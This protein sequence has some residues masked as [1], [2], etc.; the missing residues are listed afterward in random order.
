MA[1]SNTWARPPGPPSGPPNGGKR[2]RRVLI[3]DDH[4]IVR[5]GLRRV[6]ENEDDLVVCGE[7]ESARDARTAIKELH[8]DVVIADISLKQGDGIE[9]VRDVRAHHPTLPILVLSMHDE[10]IYAERMLSAGA[11]GYIMKQAA[12]D[13]FL[14]SVRRVLD[15]GIYVSEAVGTNMI[16]KFAAGGAYISANPI[17]RLS[18][19][20]LQ[21]LH[22]IGK[23]MSTR[24][25]AQSLNLSIKTIESHRQRIKRKLNLATGTQLVQYAVNWFTGRE[26]GNVAGVSK[27]S[28]A[29]PAGDES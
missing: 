5:Q 18:N 6:M 15:G 10:T 3:V 19:R 26:A 22:M 16:Q 20:E 24:E 13:Q 8:P 1:A 21:I 14:A 27:D 11:N 17:D 25:T 4:P 7:A 2:K 12:S 23:G 28:P 29:S 9:L